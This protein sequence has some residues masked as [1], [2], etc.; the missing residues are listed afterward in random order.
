MMF[1]LAVKGQMPFV[2]KY[3]QEQIKKVIEKHSRSR[4]HSGPDNH[5]ATDKAP[6]RRNTH[7]MPIL[8][9]SVYT[10]QRRRYVS[11]PTL[12]DN[13]FGS[14]SSNPARHMLQQ[15]SPEHG[16]PHKH[17]LLSSLKKMFSS[18]KDDGGRSHLSSGAIVQGDQ[19]RPYH[20]R[21]K[22]KK[23]I[24]SDIVVQNGGRSPKR[25]RVRTISNLSGVMETIEEE[26]NEILAASADQLDDSGTNSS[27][28]SS[29]SSDLTYSP[30]VRSAPE[31]TSVN[32]LL[33]SCSSNHGS[34]SDSSS[35]LHGSKPNLICG[36]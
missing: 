13:Y 14:H 9:Q 27:S 10:G 20:S 29:S 30:S 26:V 17:S 12:E 24:D 28:T 16:K 1:P 7:S 8:W 33:H 23:A 18:K 36:A 19:S 35:S 5:T 3:K 4:H 11:M 15:K 6:Q 25:Q 22:N 21:S 31:L 32:T 2:D 34:F